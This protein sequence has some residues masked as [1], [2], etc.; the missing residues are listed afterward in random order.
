[1][2]LYRVAV[3]LCFVCLFVA[4][5]TRT[6]RA[7]PKKLLRGK[8]VD[9]TANGRAEN[10]ASRSAVRPAAVFRRGVLAVE[11][12]AGAPGQ[13][14]AGRFN[15][16]KKTLSLQG[17][18]GFT[19][20]APFDIKW[21]NVPYLL[22]ICHHSSPRFLMMISRTSDVTSFRTLSMDSSVLQNR[23]TFPS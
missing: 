10:G 5:E 22:S 11:E 8:K 12:T 18:P 19:S 1:M 21:Q 16:K 6:R 7:S 15:R 14:D 2:E 23:T 13:E 17:I 9:P 4:V 20:T 3:F